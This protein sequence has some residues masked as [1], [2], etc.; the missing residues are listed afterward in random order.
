MSGRAVR[1]LLSAILGLGLSAGACGSSGGGSPPSG[2]KGTVNVA[3]LDSPFPESSIL[4]NVYGG[5][6]KGDGYTVNYELSLGTRDVVVAAMRRGEV[7]L[8]A[9]YAA[10][11]LEY[12]DG[13]R[14]EA[15]PDPN[16][17]QSRLNSY[18]QPRNL[19]ALDPAPAIDTNAFAVLRSGRYGTYARLSD[20]VPVADQMTLGGPPACPQRPFCQAGLEKTYGLRFKAFRALDASGPLTRA[21][22][23][24]GD[25]DAGLVLS[26][27]SAYSTDRYVQ[28][29]DDRHL[30]NAGNVVP[31]GRSQV[32]D[33]DVTALLNSVSA[34]LTTDAL[35]Q[36]NRRSDVD[37]QDPGQIAADW[38]RS[39]GFKT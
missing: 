35:I 3:G 23:D 2:S 20:L 33:A 27:S 11:D 15:T 6:L 38:L 18:L 12:Y 25:I 22:L 16:Q 9:G 4:A 1:A 39:N 24:R 28:L 10:T 8:Y 36:M 17:T 30:Q 31:I 29:Q 37:R 7:D 32:L 21:A 19:E 5:A 34:R 14:V 13:G 26:S